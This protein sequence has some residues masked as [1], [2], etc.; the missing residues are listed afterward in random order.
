MHCGWTYRNTVQLVYVKE[1]FQTDD[2]QKLTFIATRGKLEMG[3]FWKEI[4]DYET[5][6]PSTK[7]THNFM[8][9]Y[10]N[11]SLRG[12]VQLYLGETGGN[13]SYIRKVDVYANK[14]I[15]SGGEA[16]WEKADSF[17]PL[18]PDNL[19]HIIL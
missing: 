10:Y 19:A 12:I 3:Y 2:E 14:N 18:T 9:E 13:R 15:A 17:Y 8:S 1:M 6:F 11:L 16:D 7:T 5:N 4:G